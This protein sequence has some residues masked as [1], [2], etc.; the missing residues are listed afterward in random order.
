MSRPRLAKPVYTLVRRPNRRK[1]YVQWTDEAGKTQRISTGIEAGPG[2]PPPEA[3]AWLIA[4]QER[5]EAPPAD[6]TVADLLDA[7]LKDATGRV[8]STVNME[9]FHGRLR[10][11]FKGTAASV[12]AAGIKA[13]IRYRKDAPTSCARELEELRSAFLLAVRRRW[14]DA[15]PEFVF[16][17]KRPPRDRIISRPEAMALRDAAAALHVRIFIWLAM[18]TG[19][20]KSAILGL[21]WERVDLD[22]G[23]IDFN[24]PGRQVTKKRRAVVWIDDPDLLTALR[25]ARKIAKTGHVIEHHGKPVA[26]IKKGFAEAASRAGLDGVTPHV[27]KHSVISWLAE[28]GISVDQISDFTET[29]PQTVRRVYR[30]VNPGALRNVSQA[31]AAGFLGPVV[32][33]SP[34][35]DNPQVVGNI[36]ARDGIRTHDPLDHNHGRRPLRA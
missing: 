30:K 12:T 25:E 34:D 13:Y 33:N 19:Q 23:V 4:F 28:D 27:L 20:R 36:G 5:Q 9:W 18:L 24:D 8:V 14:L 10:L 21:L 1:W 17:P 32:R 15:C 16:P 11:Y 29:T 6:M 7:R 31:L 3:E 2:D 35:P 26:N 22:R